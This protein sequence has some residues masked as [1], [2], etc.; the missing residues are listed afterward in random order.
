MNWRRS[1]ALPRSWRFACVAGLVTVGL[2]ARLEANLPAS[3]VSHAGFRRW[4]ASDQH[5]EQA[6]VDLPGRWACMDMS[7]E[8]PATY[9]PPKAEISAAVRPIVRRRRLG[10]PCFDG[11]LPPFDSPER[12]TAANAL[13]CSRDSFRS[14]RVTRVAG[15]NDPATPAELRGVPDWARWW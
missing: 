13:F 8:N 3:M 2:T 4:A 11:C 10:A 6:V 14:G 7:P 5:P 9:N 1:S 12:T 15:K